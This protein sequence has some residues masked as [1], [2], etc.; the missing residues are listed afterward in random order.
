MTSTNPSPLP[1]SPP[2]TPTSRIASLRPRHNTKP[3]TIIRTDRHRYNTNTCDPSQSTVYVSDSTLP[4][5]QK[6]LFADRLFDGLD[7]DSALVGEYFGG[8]NL[9]SQDVFNVD[10]ISDYAI[11][12]G[13]IIRD[14]WSHVLKKVLCLTGYVNDPLDE[15]LENSM[16]DIKNS[17]LYITVKP[18]STVRPDQEFLTSYGEHAWFST[19]FPFE[20]LQKAIWRYR[21]QID[22]TESGHWPNHP[23]AHQL[24]NT[25]YNGQLPFN[26]IQCPCTTCRSTHTTSTHIQEPSPTEIER[27]TDPLQEAQ[28]SKPKSFLKPYKAQKINAKHTKPAT[29]YKKPFSPAIRTST[30]TPM[31]SEDTSTNSHTIPLI[32]LAAASNINLDDHILRQLAQYSTTHKAGSDLNREFSK[33]VY[34]ALGDDPPNAGRGL[35]A[36][37]QIKPFDIVGIYTGGENLTIQD[38]QANSY[39]SNY[40]VQHQHLVRDAQHPKTGTILCDVAF[41]NDSLDTKRHNCEWYIHPNHA[42]LLLVIATAHIPPDSQLFLPYGPDFWCQDQFSISTLLEAIRCYNIDIHSS[43]EWKQLKKYKDLCLHLPPPTDSLVIVPNTTS[44][45]NLLPTVR[46]KGGRFGDSIMSIPISSF[47]TTISR[48]HPNKANNSRQHGPTPVHTQ[49]GSSLTQ[50]HNSNQ[51]TLQSTTTGTKRKRTQGT[52]HTVQAPLDQNSKNIQNTPDKTKRKIAEVD[53]SS[54]GGDSTL[55]RRRSRRLNS[56]LSYPVISTPVP[57]DPVRP[58]NR[59]VTSRDRFDFHV[60]IHAWRARSGLLPDFISSSFTAANPTSIANSSPT[61][62]Y[63]KHLTDS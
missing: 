43:P 2:Y 28:P 24:F 20:L 56:S 34:S 46:I 3:T 37:H 22:L 35:F 31:T 25:E 38:I 17:K 52:S 7:E 54:Q 50:G 19:K 53:C 58:V 55:G 36:L 32:S 51:L 10:Y 49:Q 13:T 47:F 40:T 42:H 27:A 26:F 30:T 9:T 1:V 16:W 14:A 61:L 62:D 48:K 4:G 63:D 29:K 12:F 44:T 6:G 8:E 21:R 5:A 60:H 59:L 15:S 33:H 23:L 18:G 41:I 57:T 45:A 39:K 11:Q